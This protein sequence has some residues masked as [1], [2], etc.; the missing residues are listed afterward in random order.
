MISCTRWRAAS[1]TRRSLL[2]TRETVERDT[3]ARRAISSRVTAFSTRD[4]RAYVP[5]RASRAQRIV[6]ALPGIPR[7]LASFRLVSIPPY[8]A[9]VAPM[10]WLAP[11]E[12]L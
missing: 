7:R 3:P 5:D 8:G 11:P 6:G 1:L 9:T 10:C 2:T 12:Y 4:R